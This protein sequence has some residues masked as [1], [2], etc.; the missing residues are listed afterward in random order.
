MS[1]YDSHVS[2]IQRPYPAKSSGNR[3][4]LKGRVCLFYKPY[5]RVELKQPIQARSNDIS[6]RKVKAGQTCLFSMQL[7]HSLFPIPIFLCSSIITLIRYC[8]FKHHAY[9]SNIHPG[10]LK[11]QCSCLVSLQLTVAQHGVSASQ[12]LKQCLLNKCMN[13]YI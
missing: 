4:I 10:V 7:D 3:A 13:N 12:L 1:H 8:Y 5:H 9:F 6:R 2:G 11:Q